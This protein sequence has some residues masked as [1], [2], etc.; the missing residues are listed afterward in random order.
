MQGGI[1][2]LCVPE[3]LICSLK[4]IHL[5]H[6]SDELACCATQ[7]TSGINASQSHVQAEQGIK[8]SNAVREFSATYVLY[9]FTSYAYICT[10]NP[11]LQYI[12][13]CM[14]LLV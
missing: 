10:S 13:C 8:D 11:V 14:E 6:I 2:V 1:L 3:Q 5:R 9:S 4:F 12:F 7:A